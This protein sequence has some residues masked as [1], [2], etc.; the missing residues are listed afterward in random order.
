M[1]NRACL[2]LLSVRVCVS[3]CVLSVGGLIVH[4]VSL[5]TRTHTH[6]HIIY[7]HFS[8]HVC[9]QGTHY[10]R[11]CSE[12]HTTLSLAGRQV[13]DGGSSPD[14]EILHVE[15]N[16]GTHTRNFLCGMNNASGRF[17]SRLSY[18][19]LNWLRTYR[20]KPNYIFPRL[21]FGV[22]GGGSCD[23]TPDK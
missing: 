10:V 4:N 16:M 12:T 18:R 14:A 19:N 2:V 11:P 8:T 6:T 23:V 7:K 20:S 5:H 17:S 13:C 1:S 22:W 3:V 15:Y 21:G 9:F